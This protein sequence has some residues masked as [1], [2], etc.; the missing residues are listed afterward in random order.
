MRA[1]R[2][3]PRPGGSP[4]RGERAERLFPHQTKDV[5]GRPASCPDERV[6][7]NP[8]IG[9]ARIL[10]CGP[11]V[12]EW[13]AF[14]PSLAQQRKIARELRNEPLSKGTAWSDSELGGAG[15]ESMALA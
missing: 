11:H 12:A 5:A 15:L 9:R 1:Q 6:G 13:R 2:S 10:D 7:G 3:E 14:G 8:P 4:L